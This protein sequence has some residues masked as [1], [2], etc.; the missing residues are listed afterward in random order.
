MNKWKCTHCN[1]SSYSAYDFNED[2]YVTCTNCSRDIPN[3]YYR[4]ANSKADSAKEA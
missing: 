1:M 2:E 4:P 3:P